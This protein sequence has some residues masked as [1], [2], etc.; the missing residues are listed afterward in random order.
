MTDLRK[1]QLH[2]L[3]ILC[4]LDRICR[5]HDIKY[6]LSAG[7]LI[8]AIRHK[9]F[10]PWDDDIDTEMFYDQYL[11]FI[12]VCKTELDQNKYF[13]QTMNSDPHYNCIF[14]KLREN[15][16]SCVR[17]GQQHMKHH[18][19]IY[20]DVF[21]LYPSP[22]NKFLHKLYFIIVRRFKVMLRAR[23]GRANE[24]RPFRRFKYKVYSKIPLKI[25]Q[26]IIRFIVSLCK[27]DTYFTSLGC[28]VTQRLQRDRRDYTQQIE[29]EFEGHNFMIPA[30]YDKILTQIYGDY[31]TPPP[32]N[33]RIGRHTAVNIDHGESFALPRHLEESNEA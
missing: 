27:N 8:G 26:N 19:G 6:H 30:N 25:P 11:K 22:K 7:T 15:N 10:I 28:P 17:L 21:P 2:Q 29:A 20:I 5:K 16:T 3:E 4:E 23:V 1:L 31:M 18:H 9:G 12:E 13:L 24:V 14:A 33:E 32:E